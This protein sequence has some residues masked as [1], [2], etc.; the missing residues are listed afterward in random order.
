MGTSINITVPLTAADVT[1]LSGGNSLVL[2]LTPPAPAVVTPTPTPTPTPVTTGDFVLP[3]GAM[4]IYVNG[5]FYWPGDWSWGTPA[6][7]VNYAAPGGLD[8]TCVEFQEN[9]TYSGWQPYAPLVNGN[10]ELLQ[11]S[12]NFLYMSIKATKPASWQSGW[13]QTVAATPTEDVSVGITVNLAGYA[14]GA[15]HDGFQDYKIPLGTGGYGLPAGV[16]LRKFMVQD[17]TGDGTNTFY[18]D[19]VYLSPV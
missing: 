2:T 6:P 16:L 17:D 8:G 13:M 11:G 15:V 7:I 3:E 9:G 4:P 10:P 5:K 1:G 12:Q 18:F 14:V 19:R